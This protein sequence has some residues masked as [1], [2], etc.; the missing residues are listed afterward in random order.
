MAQAV[1]EEREDVH[2]DEVDAVMAGTRV[3]V[4]LSARSVAGLDG[5]ITLPQFRVLVMVAST[6][7]V[8]LG[9]GPGVRP[10]SSA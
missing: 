7:P 10:G 8:N 1:T 6:R 5:Q 4:A 9:A 3:L 2:P